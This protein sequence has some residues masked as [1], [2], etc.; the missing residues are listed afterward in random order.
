ME[1]TNHE[2]TFLLQDPSTKILVSN[3]MMQVC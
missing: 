1:I 2:I 3:Y